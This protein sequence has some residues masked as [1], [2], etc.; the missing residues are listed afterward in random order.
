MEKFADR[1]C[2]NN[3]D[4]FANADTAYTLAFSVIMLNTDL[5]RFFPFFFVC[6][7]LHTNSYKTISNQVK[8]KMTK[9]QF[10][11]NNRGINNGGN[12]EDAFLDQIYDDISKDEIVMEE[13]QSAELVKAAAAGENLSTQQLQELH[14]MQVG[15]LTRKLQTLLQQQTS[16]TVYHSGSHAEHVGPMFEVA[17]MPILAAF[18]VLFEESTDADTD[19]IAL[20]LEGFT[21]VS[22][23]RIFLFTHFISCLGMRFTSQAKTCWPLRSSP[24]SSR[25]THLL[26]FQT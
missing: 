8:N 26:C 10:L 22:I 5:H 9:Q 23:H 15:Q 16:A 2:E 18:A 7:Q 19:M 17:W 14:R 21:Y 12:L 13:E 3:P 11:R 24:L 25:S 1:F 6:C 20:V 4:I